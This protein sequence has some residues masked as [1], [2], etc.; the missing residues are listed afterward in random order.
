MVRSIVSQN[1]D[2]YG[3]LAELKRRGEKFTPSVLQELQYD[4]LILAASGNAG[5]CRCS[6]SDVVNEKRERRAL[7]LSMPKARFETVK[8]D[9][10]LAEDLQEDRLMIENKLPSW[11]DL[12]PIAKLYFKLSCMGT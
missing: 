8:L 1:K 11:S 5:A 7:L 9:D 12:S 3:V 6:L 2:F 10:V 4:Q